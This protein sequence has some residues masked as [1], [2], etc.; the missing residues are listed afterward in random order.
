MYSNIPLFYLFI[1]GVQIRLQKRK[2]ICSVAT[3]PPSS[4]V[5]RR[6]DTGRPKVLDRYQNQ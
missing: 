6:D 5:R 3:A 4:V 2:M 1:I